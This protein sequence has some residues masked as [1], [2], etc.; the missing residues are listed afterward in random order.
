MSELYTEQ[1]VTEFKK[2]RN[3]YKK[4]FDDGKNDD[5]FLTWCAYMCGVVKVVK[6]NKPVDVAKYE[7]SNS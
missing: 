1:D 2:L 4:T 6:L 5:A 7:K 3:Y